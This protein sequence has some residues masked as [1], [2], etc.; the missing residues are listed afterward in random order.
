[1]KLNDLID[2]SNTKKRIVRYKEKMNDTYR[3][4]CYY[5][6]KEKWLCG[7]IKNEDWMKIDIVDSE[8]RI[9]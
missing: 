9:N 8:W 1:M 6:L 2:P 5:N 3:I 4:I 7:G